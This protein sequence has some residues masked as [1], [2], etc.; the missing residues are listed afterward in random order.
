MMLTVVRTVWPCSRVAAEHKIV[1]SHAVSQ[2]VYRIKSQWKT[3]HANGIQF[4]K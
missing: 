4:S 3:D 2:I 1:E